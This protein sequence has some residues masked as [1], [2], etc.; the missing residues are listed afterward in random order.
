MANRIKS[1]TCVLANVALSLCGLAAFD[2]PVKNFNANTIL[3]TFAQ[4]RKQ[5]FNTSLV[6]PEAQEVIATDDG[7]IKLVILEHQ[8]E[9]NWFES[10]LGNCVIIE[11]EGNLISVYGNLERRDAEDVLQKE[12]ILSGE[13]LGSAKNSAWNESEGSLEFQIADTKDKAFLNPLV[14]MPKISSETPLLI[15]EI[16]IENKFGRSYELSSSKSV[17]AGTYKVYKRRR[18]NSPL[19][20]SSVYVNGTELERIDREALSQKDNLL[21]ISGQRAYNSE[22]FFPDERREFL[23]QILLLNG[24]NSISIII[25]N[26]MEKERTVLFTVQAY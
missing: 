19:H 14:F 17:Q 8:D 23:G 6:F 25:R 5:H 13:N 20:S 1:L 2:W 24:N 11:H 4:N 15:D 7:K 3:P 10:P 21:T 18:E 26:V 16:T 22:S 9:C 12:R